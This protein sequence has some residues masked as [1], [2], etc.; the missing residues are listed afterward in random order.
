MGTLW[1][2]GGNW[3]LSPIVKQNK[4]SH[5][6]TQ[7]KNSYKNLVETNIGVINL[8]FP[9][10]EKFIFLGRKKYFSGQKNKFCIF[11]SLEQKRNHQIVVC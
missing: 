7:V 4:G 10:F 1:L 9:W 8:I 3:E 5:S 2:R 11:E 6:E